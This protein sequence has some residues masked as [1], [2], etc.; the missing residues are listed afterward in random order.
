MKLTAFSHPIVSKVYK[1]ITPIIGSKKTASY[2]ALTLSLFTLSF[3]GLFAIRPTLIT[4]ISLTKKVADLRKLYVDY[5]NKISSLIKA[6]GEYEQ[7]RNDIPLIGKALP[8]NPSSGKLAQ[9]VEKFAARE[10]FV[11]SQFQIDPVPIS[12]PAPSGKLYDYN[13]VLV[14]IGKYPAISAFL[15]HLVNWQRIVNIKSLEFTQ[16]GGTSSANLRVS[17]KAATFYE[18]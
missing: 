16:T 7:I 15:N 12:I 17:I 13:F 2:F 3:F 1:R 8:A 18:P 6:Q 4:A 14:G 10:N 9:A 5:E 11:I